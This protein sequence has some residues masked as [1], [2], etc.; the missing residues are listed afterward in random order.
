MSKPKAIIVPDLAFTS[1]EGRRGGKSNGYKE[2]KGQLKY[3]QYRDD[4]DGH[5][6][7]ETGLERW[8]DRGLGQNYR[9]IVNNCNRFSS[10]RLLA[11]TWVVSPAPDL[12][13]LVPE[14]ERPELVLT[15]TEEIVEAYYAARHVEMPEYAYVLH[16]RWTNA[17]EG[18][19]PSSSFIRMSCFPRP[20]RLSKALARTSTT[21]PTRATSNCFKKF[22]QPS[23]KPR[24]TNTLARSGAG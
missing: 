2:L 24:S 5:I 9:E 18:T 8:V 12:M 21:A 19:E 4:R 13:A 20:F 14:R 10:N 15:L 11:W 3:F 23:L 17:E 22:L 6:P 16:D 1:H 7:Q